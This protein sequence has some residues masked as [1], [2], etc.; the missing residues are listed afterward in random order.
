M[1][2]NFDVDHSGYP[3]AAL[4]IRGVPHLPNRT[5][6]VYDVRTLEPVQNIGFKQEDAITCAGYVNRARRLTATGV[7]FSAADAQAAL[8]RAVELLPEGSAWT[9]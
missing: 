3:Y 9:Y 1:R 8:G 2:G 4:A 5:H 6:A 7:P